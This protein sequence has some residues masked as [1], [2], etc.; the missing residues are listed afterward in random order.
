MPTPAPPTSRPTLTDSEI[1][2][3]DDAKAA[4]ITVLEAGLPEGGEILGLLVDILW[5][6]TQEDV[7][8]EIKGQVEALI[9]QK[10]ADNVYQQVSD[11]LRGLKNSIILYVSEINNGTVDDQRNQWLI[12]RNLFADA[13]PHFQSANY[14]LLLSPLFAHFANM[15][16]AIL[17]DGVIFGKAWG[18]SAADQAQ[19]TTNLTSAIDQF[20][21]YTNGIYVAG[22]NG[23]R[24]ATG[25][26]F[27]SVNSY[28]REMT[29]TVLNFMDTWPYYDVTKYPTGATVTLAREIYS[30]PYGRTGSLVMDSPP[31]QRPTSISVW[32]WDE[33]DAV[34]LT[35]P[36]GS[37]PGGVT[38]TK[39]MGDQYGGATHT[40]G[41]IV[42]V[43]PT[44]PII[45]ARATYNYDVPLTLQFLFDD[46]TTTPLFGGA[47]TRGSGPYDSGFVGFNYYALSSIYATGPSSYPSANNVVF[48]YQLWKSPQLMSSAAQAIYV[49]SPV[50]RSAADLAKSFPKLAVSNS[51][52]TQ[53]LK[54]ARQAYW[55]TF[56]A[57]A[58]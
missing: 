21:T 48:G 47:G 31:T 57:R 36:A 51:F 28:D 54:N 11:D 29:M 50:E 43:S 42:S 33:L 25:G 14:E 40:H 3:N 30:D 23:R 17:R 10:I 20:T 9:N 46:G 38:T 7:W 55:T 49:K 24:D 26:A 15:Y 2:W 16:L 45:G 27:S 58:K 35:Y 44:N 53:E 8:G 4:V 56:K 12:T 37:G 22:H 34:Q 5:P 1:D 18:R 39:R 52:F 6:N 19:D 41:G 32:A 13:L